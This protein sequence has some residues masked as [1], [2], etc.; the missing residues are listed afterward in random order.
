M[1]WFSNY[2]TISTVQSEAVNLIEQIIQFTV[3][4]EAYINLLKKNF[5]Y[6]HIIL[7]KRVKLK[8]LTCPN[9]C[10][11]L[12]LITHDNSCNVS[13]D[14]SSSSKIDQLPVHNSQSNFASEPIDL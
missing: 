8:V 3:V 5:V 7:S 12:T 4:I 9:Q 2:Y 11:A 13:V 14:C 1:V 6:T 10:K